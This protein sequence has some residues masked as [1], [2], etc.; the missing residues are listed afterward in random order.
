MRERAR[1]LGLWVMGQRGVKMKIRDATPE[2]RS[3]E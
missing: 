1:D 2:E 3:T